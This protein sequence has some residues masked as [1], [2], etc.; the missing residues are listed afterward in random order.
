MRIAS[1]SCSNVRP[2][3]VVRCAVVGHVEWIEF[4]EID[5]FPGRGEIVRATETWQD[6]AG[7][8]PVAAVQLAKLAGACD[9]FTALGDDELGQRA[10]K[11]LEARGLTPHVQWK[12]K[13]TRRGFVF[14]D[15]GGERTIT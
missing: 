9:F 8:G 13:P 3:S 1:T 7:G 11:E 5:R 2:S 4:A 15:E 10:A 6:A 14:L 12:A